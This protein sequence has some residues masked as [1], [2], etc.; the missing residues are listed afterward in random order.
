MISTSTKPKGA[1]SYKQTT[2]GIISRTK[3]LQLELE[4]TKKGLELIGKSVKK[5]LSPEYIL[6]LHRVAFILLNL[7]LPPVEIM[8][9]AEKDRN[10]YLQAMYSADEDNM[11]KLEKL[12]RSALDE[13]LRVLLAA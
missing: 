13:S 12:I 7:G 11:S 6:E 5:K 9:G 4:G 1:T 2:F 10:S 8:A 3:L